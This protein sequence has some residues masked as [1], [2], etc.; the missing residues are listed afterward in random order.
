MVAA[1]GGDAPQVPRPVSQAVWVVASLA[2]LAGPRVAGGY[3]N[4]HLFEIIDA[5]AD[6]R[7]LDCGDLDDMETD[8]PHTF[9][10]DLKRKPFKMPSMEDMKDPQ[11]W[12]M[13]ATGGT[14]MT[15]ATL[16]MQK[17]EQLGK[18]GT[19]RL[20]SQWKTMLETGSALASCYAVD[21]GKILFVT[22]QAGMVQ[23][24]KEFVLS[25]PDV[26]WFEFNQQRFFPQGRD[27]PLMDNEERKQRELE[28]GWR[29]P[30]PASA[31]KD[32]KKRKAKKS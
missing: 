31:K 26:D 2:A 13:G 8:V 15:F 3:A 17:A 12:A 1:V 5:E 7:D 32:S 24:L 18:E 4:P 25:Q 22:T 6:I 20:A 14:Q 19:D 28:L 29:K 9:L 16:T 23:K 11:A 10:E 21:P 27:Y 30:P